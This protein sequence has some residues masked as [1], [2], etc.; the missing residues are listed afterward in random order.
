[1]NKNIFFN[2]SKLFRINWKIYEKLYQ[3]VIEKT[4][5][6]KEERN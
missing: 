4:K 6:K 1:M 5:N 2:C 3:Y